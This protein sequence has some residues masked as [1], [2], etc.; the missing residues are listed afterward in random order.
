LEDRLRLRVKKI[1][2]EAKD[3]ITLVLEN[4]VNAAI[5]YKSGQ[6]ITIFTTINQREV[7][8]SYSLCSAPGIDKFLAISIKRIVNGEVSRH[9]IDTLMEGDIVEC[10]HPAGRFTFEP[11]ISRQRDIFLIG[12][13]SGASPLFSILKTILKYEPL[14]RIIF[15]NSNK[16]K[17][18]TF[19]WREMN[20][21][22]LQ[23]G[24]RFKLFNV[25]SDAQMEA[26]ASPKR[27][28]I[29]LLQMLI[30]KNI[31]LEKSA[32]E[33]YL[34]GPF[35]FMRMAKMTMIYMGFNEANIHKET[36]F[37]NIGTPVSQLPQYAGTRKVTIIYKGQV[38]ELD[39]PASKSILRT[40]LD[41]KIYLPYSCEGGKCSTCM[42]KCEHG[43]VKMLLNEVLTENEVALGW[44]L[45]CTSYPLED[46]IVI[47]LDRP[48]V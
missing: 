34:C 30:Y 28:H 32:A 19:Y 31:L 15:I 23:Y 44:I 24:E 21:F 25:F 3:T 46:G 5:E 12:A 48:F 26:G 9:L 40:A 8:R 7:R 20:E 41:Q 37:S 13:G 29:A 39:V 1:I 35:E 36:F 47:N 4:T 33:F 43:N 6:F 11:D 45:T 16:N 14:S 42:G 38:I 2:A 27:L 10:L 22:A 17:H 18:T